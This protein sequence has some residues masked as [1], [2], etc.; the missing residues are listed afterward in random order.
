M[1][2]QSNSSSSC[3]GFSSYFSFCPPLS[4]RRPG[5][6]ARPRS[7][8]RRRVLLRLLP[9]APRVLMREAPAVVVINALLE[10]GA[11]VRAYDPEAMEEAQHR[12]LADRIEYATSPM[13]AL[14]GADALILITEWNEFRR[15]DF[16]AIKEQLNHPVIFD[17]RNIYRRETL[18]KLGFDYYGIGT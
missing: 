5:S 18:G 4:R 17:G 6:A 3:L 7:W 16:E 14:P 12:H 11:S 9:L 8:L 1:I 10:A 13:D 2:L 15:P